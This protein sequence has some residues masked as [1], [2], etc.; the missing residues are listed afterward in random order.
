MGI[1]RVSTEE[2]SRATA[3]QRAWSAEGQRAWGDCLR[4]K[5][6]VNSSPNVS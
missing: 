3:V 2:V 6:S 5:S 4:E 1:R